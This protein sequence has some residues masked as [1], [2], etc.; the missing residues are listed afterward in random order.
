MFKELYNIICDRLGPDNNLKIPKDLVNSY[1]LND[2]INSNIRDLKGRYL[3]L[4]IN[5]TLAPLI[6]QN[7]RLQNYSKDMF[8]C[9][10]L[11]F[12]RASYLFNCC[13]GTQRNALEQGIKFPKIKCIF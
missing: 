8:H 5:P 10:I 1:N 11:R 3:L 6:T 2:C 12:D 13:D 9:S 7:I 4:G